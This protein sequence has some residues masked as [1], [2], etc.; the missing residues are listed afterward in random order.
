MPT[1]VGVGIPQ[2]HFN[3]HEAPFN[4][5]FIRGEVHP[6]WKFSFYFQAEALPH[7]A[8]VF[9][10]QKAASLT[11]AKAS[12]GSV[13]NSDWSYGGQQGLTPTLTVSV[14]QLVPFFFAGW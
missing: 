8:E 3:L 4:I 12:R 11:A 10:V 13:S 1:P 7:F 5:F 9:Q 6:G 14:S 2:A